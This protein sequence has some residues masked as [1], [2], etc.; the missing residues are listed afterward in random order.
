YRFLGG[1]SF[2]SWGL[3]SPRNAGNASSKASPQPTM[4]LT[5]SPPKKDR[6]NLECFPARALA[7]H[8]ETDPMIPCPPYRGKKKRLVGEKNRRPRV[9]RQAA[10]PIRSGC[11]TSIL[12]RSV[13]EGHPSL[14]LRARIET[15]SSKRE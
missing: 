2:S 5:A 15:D 3:A 7:G 13:S 14:T 4:C 9:L 6:E 8:A 10:G 11:K 12:A 1:G